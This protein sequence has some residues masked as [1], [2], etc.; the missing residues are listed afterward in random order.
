MISLTDGT[1]ISVAGIGSVCIISL[2]HFILKSRCRNISL[3]GGF[4]R[5]DRDVIPPHELNN[6]VVVPPSR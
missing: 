3:C 1:I 2:L 4:I 6:V 5:C